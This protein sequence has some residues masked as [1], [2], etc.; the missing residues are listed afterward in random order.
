MRL[1]LLHCYGTA[2]WH[3]LAFVCQML[4]HRPSCTWC[5]CECSLV[6]GSAPQL[7]LDPC[8]WKVL[9]E[10]QL[11]TIQR[12]EGQLYQSITGYQHP[13]VQPQLPARHFGC[14][15]LP[16]GQVPGATGVTQK[17]PGKCRVEAEPH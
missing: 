5:M 15:W 14:L 16:C 6:G 9:L 17:L 1:G 13:A 2:T 8:P 7:E 12:K 10:M 3:V 11:G 4:L